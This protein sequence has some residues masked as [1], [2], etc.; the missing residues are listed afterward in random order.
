MK[1]F[2]QRGIDDGLHQKNWMPLVRGDELFLVYSSDPTVVLSVDP[3]T[4]KSRRIVEREPS[5]ALHDLRG[6][7]QVIAFD[8]GW[9]YVAHE[10]FAGEPGRRYTHRLV[11]MNADFEIERLSDP[12]VFVGLGIE[13]CAGLAHDSKRKLLIFSFGVD[14][15]R[16]CL[17]V[18]SAGK[19]RTALR[20]G[21]STLS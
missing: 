3:K 1:G 9:L 19:V 14:D 2:V 11:W 4:M 16:G 21:R 8:K 15:K 5:V 7:S 13:F 12:F 6:G 17:A 18:A 10:V 20:R